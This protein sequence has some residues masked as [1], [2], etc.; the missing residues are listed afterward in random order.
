MFCSR[1]SA[2]A[3]NWRGGESKQEAGRSTADRASRPRAN[4]RCSRVLCALSLAPQHWSQLDT[5][6][7]PS[8]PRETDSISAESRATLSSRLDSCG[9][10]RGT[11]QLRLRSLARER[12]TV[13]V[14]IRHGHVSRARSPR[15]NTKQQVVVGGSRLCAGVQH[16]CV[17]LV[18][19]A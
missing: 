7:L 11:R 12:Q 5:C 8:L 17:P 4:P 14:S 3:G 15:T 6:L 13:L 1:F 9:A 2:Q 16:R 18:W 19:P 10:R